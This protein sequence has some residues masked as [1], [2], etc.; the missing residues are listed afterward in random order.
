M[1]I[2]DRLKISR[3]RMGWSQ[4]RMEE[5]SGYS[6]NSIIN[7]ETGVRVPRADIL[8]EL[9]KLLNTTVAYLAGESDEHSPAEAPAEKRDEGDTAEKNSPLLNLVFVFEALKR[10]SSKMSAEE[11]NAVTS[12]LKACLHE[13]EKNN[14]S[15]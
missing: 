13:V 12:L 10:S 14:F 8:A 1:A 5:E 2:G 3:E 9:A 6:R 15:A 11:K 4:Y 7:W